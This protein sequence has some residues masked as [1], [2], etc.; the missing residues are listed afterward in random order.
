MQP[1][2]HRQLDQPQNV[3]SRTRTCMDRT[4]RPR[5]LCQRNS[6]PLAALL[7]HPTPSPCSATLSLIGLPGSHARPCCL[8]PVLSSPPPLQ[9]RI[10]FPHTRLLLLARQRPRHRPRRPAQPPR[11]RQ[12]RAGRLE[13]LRAGV[14]AASPVTRVVDERVCLL[15]P[16]RRPSQRK[17]RARRPPVCTPLR[18]PC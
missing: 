3:R 8:S 14:V 5:L 11:P 10:H 13:E 1:L 12:D 18:R 15:S 9:M 7:K 17:C 6:E 2:A 4:K 16:H